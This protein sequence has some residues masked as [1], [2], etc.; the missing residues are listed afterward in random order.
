M[1]S[2]NGLLALAPL[3]SRRIIETSMACPPRLKLQGN[4]EKGILKAAMT[5]ILPAAIINRPKSGMMVPVRFW[6]QGEMRRY[7]R[8]LLSKRNLKR[9]GFF[10]VEYV[11]KILDYDKSEIWGNRHGLKLWMLVTFMLWYEQMVEGKAPSW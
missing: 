6:M 8:R 9:T 10:N 5:D 4:I 2:A 1:T 7:A 11:R 3:F